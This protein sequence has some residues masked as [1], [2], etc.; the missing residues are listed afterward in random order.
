M[1][2]QK[3]MRAVMRNKE[4]F[5]SGLSTWADG[6]NLCLTSLILNRLGGVGEENQFAVER[7]SVEDQEKSK[8]L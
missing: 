1:R 7:N 6:L 3:V 4:L 2:D 8:C 5:S